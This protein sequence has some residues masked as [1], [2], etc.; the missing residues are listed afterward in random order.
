MGFF[1]L[2][3]KQNDHNQQQQSEPAG[4]EIS[5]R[6]AIRPNRQGAEQQ[7][8]DKNDKKEAHCCGLFLAGHFTH[9]VF[10]V[11]NG[12]PYLAFSFF[13]LAFGFEMTIAHD[14][15]GFFLDGTSRLLYAAFDP[16]FIHGSCSK[17]S[18]SWQ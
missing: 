1:V 7:D 13:G 18:D 6:S 8:Q 9:R 3:K 12:R 15:A 16:I 17:I 10:C 11:P 14:L 5:P 2:E 4:W